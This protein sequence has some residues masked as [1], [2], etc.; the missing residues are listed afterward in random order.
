[1]LGKHVETGEIDALK[2]MKWSSGAQ[3]KHNSDLFDNEVLALKE[4]NHPNILKLKESG[5]NYKVTNAYG[6]P[7]EISYITLEFAENGELFDYIA[8]G[9][10]WSEE[11]VRY[12][13][14]QIIETLEYMH[15]KGYSHRDIKPENILLDEEFNIKFADFGFS[16]KKETIGG[17]RGTIGYMAPEVLAGFEHDP[18]K[19]DLF[20]AAVILFIM[21]TK[22]CP[23]LKASCTDRYYK[24]VAQND[25]DKFWKMHLNSNG[26]KKEFSDSFKDLCG[27]MFSL[28]PSERPT[29][30]EVKEHE[31]Y[32]GL[33][34]THEEIKELFQRTKESKN[35]FSGDS[36]KN[37][38]QD[39]AW[40]YSQQKSSKSMQQI[41]KTETLSNSKSHVSMS[42]TSSEEEYI[43]DYVMVVNG[44]FLVDAVT[45]FW[46]INQYKY[47][48]SD[49][50]FRIT[51]K[52]VEEN[53]M[54]VIRADILKRDKDSSRAI[55]LSLLSGSKPL[56]KSTFTKLWKFVRE[57]ISEFD[58]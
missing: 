19:A 36:E 56:L 4:F 37:A 30:D 26:V 33:I 23:F 17:K 43:T 41:A 32:N 21:K 20:S 40:T 53:D 52:V 14:H 8:E 18:K 50:Y 47:E 31:W 54:S 55:E 15:K 12:F 7:I 57:H 24:V 27:R 49:K 1:M 29:I 51:F 6:K 13:F 3:A 42:G 39:E 38:E 48:K 34:A 5:S 10:N 9:E 2:I 16:T 11:V 46:D 28:N 22:H 35:E 25:L 58:N 45:W 44:E